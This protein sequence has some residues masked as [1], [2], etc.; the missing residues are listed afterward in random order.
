M[1]AQNVV[2]DIISAANIVDVISDYVNLRKAGVNYKGVCPF[3]GDRDASLVVSPAKNIWKCF[4]C[5]KGGNVITFLMDHE[6]LSFFE[7][8]KQVASKYNITV[9]ERELTDDEKNKAR[10]REALHICLQF[11]QEAFTGQL[12]KKI[13]EEYLATRYIRPEILSQYGVGYAPAGFTWLAELAGQKGYDSATMEQAGLISRKESG[14][15]FDRFI[16]RITFPF[17]SLS[18]KVIGFTGRALEKDS[19]CKYLNSPE[20]QVFHKGKTLYGIYQARPEITKNDK[21]YLVEGQF[22]VLSFVQYGFPNTV[23]GSGTA[24]TQEQVRMLKKFTRNV[25]AVYDGDAAGMKASIRNMDVMLSEGMNVRAVLLPEQEDPDSFARKMGPEKLAKFIKRNEID[26]ISFIY[27]AFEK[28]ME[29]PI[30]K[31]EVLRVVAQSISVVPDKLQ[32]QAYIATLATKFK[33]DGELITA[34]VAELQGMGKKEA[35][36]QPEQSGFT[37]LEDAARLIESEGKQITLTWSVERFTENWGDRPTVLVTGIPGIS[38]IQE[39]RRV[40]SIVRCRDRFKLNEETMEEPKEL[41]FLRSLSYTGFTVSMSRYTNRQE[42]YVDEE[43]K[44]RRKNVELEKEIGFN[45]YYISLYSVFK[46]A[47]EGL[48]K[49]ALER[50]AELISH[51]DATTRAFQ[52]TEYARALG[53]TKTALDHV[54]KPYLDVRKSEARFNSDALQVDGTALMF[55]PSRLPDYVEKDPEIN[56]LWRAYQ[57]FPYLDGNG[58]KVAYIFS[59]GKKSYTRIGNFYIEPLLHVYDKESQANKRIVQLTQANYPYP[60]FMEWISAEMITLQTFRKRLWEEGDINFSNGTQNHLDLIMDSWAGKFK[61]CFELRMFG[62]YDEGFFAFSNAIVHEIDGKQQLQY[63]TDLGLVEHNNQ[64]YYIPAFSKIYA[65][66]RRDSDRYFLDRFIKYREPKGLKVDFRGWASLMNEV[67]KLNNNGKWAIIY[68]IMSAFRSDIYNVRRTFT[69]LFFIGPTGSGKSQVGYSIRSLSMPPDAPTFNL[70]SGTPAALF[71]WLERYRNIPIMLEEYNDR[72]INP[73]I[74]QALKSAVYDGEGKQ[75]RKDAVSKEIDSSQVNAALIIM[76]QESPQQDDNSLANR[77]IICD[78]PKCDDRTEEEE[79]VFNQLK[80]YEEN[81][82]HNVLL[83]ILSCRKTLLDNYV[84]VYGEVFKELKDNARVLVTNTDGLSRILETVSMFLTVCRIVEE[85]TPLQLP[86]T[87]R[88]FFEIAV[89]KVAKQ[90]ESISTSNKMFN[91]FSNINYLIDT[92]S[93]RPGRDYK[94]EVP[95]KITLK[96][97]GKDTEIKVM[98]PADT[99]VLYL[100]MT[101]IYPM[102]SNLAKNEALSMQ[103]LNTY[104]E[105]NEAYIG[106]VRSTRFRWQE[107]KEI[108]RGE[109]SINEDG[110]EIVDNTMKRIM[111]NKESNTSAVVFD[112]DRLKDLLDVDFERDER[113]DIET[114]TEGKFRF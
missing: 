111:T 18:G 53:V 15:V 79:N 50:C 34:L 91:F 20:T 98:E 109:I 43:G 6:G 106:R 22:D 107:V 105:S 97:K 85:S 54:L 17:Y 55:D 30:R 47:T 9:P 80:S 75:K 45:E 86:F 29:D 57:F 56:R 51:A 81:G 82:L 93:I 32:R 3:H 73:V 71:S 39:L 24:L 63:V 44:E 7:A 90:V 19:Q 112:Y 33:A 64:Y 92:G 12:E 67:Y 5:G 113:M 108:P 31:T 2:D 14:K 59:N 36:K 114:E 46:E 76:G 58:R 11:S 38:E 95:G 72:D 68:S 61:K 10:E 110:T 70:N 21:V 65:S 16:N 49:I 1:I 27:K 25:T 52:A 42:N 87:Y 101:N 94:I 62:W 26:F 96:T 48:K 8:A 4:G 66:E 23:C 89:E 13:P 37:G 83:E 88:D 84:K 77:C 78:V 41:V 69:A 60:V 99:R 28:E 35:I 103:S 40:S 74:F 100:N 102:Y 104:F